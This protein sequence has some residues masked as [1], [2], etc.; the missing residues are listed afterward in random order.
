MQ[1]VKKYSLFSTSAMNINDRSK[2]LLGSMVPNNS[3]DFDVIMDFPLTGFVV[4]L[5]RELFMMLRC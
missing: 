2:N 5:E 4:S 3:V 1:F